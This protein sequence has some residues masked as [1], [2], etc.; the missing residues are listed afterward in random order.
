MGSE[1]LCK[2]AETCASRASVADNNARPTS[3]PKVT[4]NSSA[5]R[6][7]ILLIRWAAMAGEVAVVCEDIVSNVNTRGSRRRTEA[8]VLGFGRSGNWG[9]VSGVPCSLFLFGGGCGF[10]S[11]KKSISR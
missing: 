6:C 7:L 5:A 11:P 2:D 4:S 1:K 9:A 8:W 3:A 10:L